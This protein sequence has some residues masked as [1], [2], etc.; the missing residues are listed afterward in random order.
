MGYTAPLADIVAAGLAGVAGHA[1]G[2]R[3]ALRAA[4]RH[5]EVADMA[6]HAQAARYSLGRLLGGDEG[7]EL[8][9]R[10]EAALAAAGVRAPRR[11]AAMLVPGSWT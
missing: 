8:A 5:A 9:A 4:V 1:D 3:D 11:F 10:A 6:L 7:R 2:A